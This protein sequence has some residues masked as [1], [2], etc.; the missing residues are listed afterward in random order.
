MRSAP[1]AAPHPPI[2]SRG[3]TA[4]LR[5]MPARQPAYP[6]R[7]LICEAT[8]RHPDRDRGRASSQLGRRGQ[9]VPTHV[10]QTA[11]DRILWLAP[12][13]CNGLPSVPWS[14]G[15]RTVAAWYRTPSNS[16]APFRLS[17][18]AITRDNPSELRRLAPSHVAELMRWPASDPARRFENVRSSRDSAT[19]IAA[20][21]RR[22]L[23]RHAADTSVQI[24]A[25]KHLRERL[26]FGQAGGSGV[27]RD[28]VRRKS[29]PEFRHGTRSRRSIAGV[30]PRASRRARPEQS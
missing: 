3:H 9:L 6:A 29:V 10:D 4:A 13:D 22:F 30:C 19:R 17:F 7:S 2:R 23:T 14:A 18:P 20:R 8:R 16:G 15:K 1:P 28:C 26:S 12:G 11:F 27:V 24:K 21:S 25:Q 5:G